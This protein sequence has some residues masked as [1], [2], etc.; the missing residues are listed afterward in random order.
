MVR[1]VMTDSKLR[2]S[3]LS[4]A[5]LLL[6]LPILPIEDGLLAKPLYSYRDEQGTNVITDHYE[7]VPERY[8]AKVTTIEQEADSAGSSV[9]I[10]RGV[11]GF[12]KGADTRIGEATINVPGMSPYQSHALTITGSLALF[13]FALRKFS[14]SQVI[15]F[16]SLWG[17]IML[18]LVTPIFIYFSQDAALDILRGEASHIQTKQSEHLKQAH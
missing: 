16:L 10:S 11:A 3:A 7:R 17:L 15:R 13:F 1:T 18:G 5:F 2:W 12:L 6:G 8:R 14:R 9:D 4:I